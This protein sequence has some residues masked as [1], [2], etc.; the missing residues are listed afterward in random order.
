MISLKELLNESLQINEGLSPEIKRFL[1]SP[2][3]TKCTTDLGSGWIIGPSFDY[4]VK[5]TEAAFDETLQ[6]CIN[7]F[8]GVNIC[9]EIVTKPIKMKEALKMAENNG[10]DPEGSMWFVYNEGEEYPA[11]WSDFLVQY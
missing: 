5:N 8:G 3:C 11:I 4:Y 2:D 9:G 10:E 1:Q 6:T 7:K